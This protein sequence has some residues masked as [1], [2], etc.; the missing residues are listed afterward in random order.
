MKR[1]KAIRR[2]ATL[3]MLS[4]VAEA[5]RILRT[6]DGKPNRRGERSV[7]LYTGD[8]ARYMHTSPILVREGE[9]PGKPLKSWARREN[10][11]PAQCIARAVAELV[12]LFTF[13]WRF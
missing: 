4:A 5:N 6:N 9:D 2:L 12:D 10:E 7:L 8:V 11:T 1:K 3:D 13:R